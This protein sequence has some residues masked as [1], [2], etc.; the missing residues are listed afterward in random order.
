MVVAWLFTTAVSS[1][2]P[3]S[4]TTDGS[5]AF[6]ATAMMPALASASEAYMCTTLILPDKPLTLLGVTPLYKAELVHHMLMLGERPVL[7]MCVLCG[8]ISQRVLCCTFAL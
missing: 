3:S 5:L 1:T 4:N 6:Q 8:P 7:S 2:Q